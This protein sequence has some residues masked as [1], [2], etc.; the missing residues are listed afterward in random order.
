VTIYVVGNA[1]NSLVSMWSY[2]E[3]SFIYLWR[4]ATLPDAISTAY[5]EDG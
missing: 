4:E 1:V 3:E 5:R 2:G